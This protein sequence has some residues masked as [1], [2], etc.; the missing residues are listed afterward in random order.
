MI[1]RQVNM[2]QVVSN[3]T[4]VCR[5]LACRLWK[6]WRSCKGPWLA[7]SRHQ[8]RRYEWHRSVACASEHLIN[9]RLKAI[10]SHFSYLFAPLA[11]DAMQGDVTLL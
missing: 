3:R 10:S 11:S 5:R 8:S 2:Q 1:I 9:S 6:R 4:I 7:D